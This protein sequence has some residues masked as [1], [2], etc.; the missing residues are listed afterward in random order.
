MSLHNLA[1]M[2]TATTG[3][4]S[5]ITLGSA[6]PGFLTFAQAGVVNGETVPYGII[7]GINSETGTGVYTSAGTTLTRIPTKSTNGDALISLSGNALVSITARAEDIVVVDKA[8]TFSA[9]QTAGSA[10]ITSG[11]APDFSAKQLFT[12]A[13]SGSTF[14]VA[15][16]SADPANNTVILLII[17]FTTANL[18]SFGTEYKVTGYTPSA[19]G[20]DALTF[21]YDS[22]A[23]L[24]YLMGI[25]KGISF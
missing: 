7:D 17:S 4:T 22:A 16:P 21:V 24:Y 25:R 2:T 1:R 9:P 10:A 18:V 19:S 5:P 12:I 11:V 20:K 3:T 13:V 15:N 23:G 6:V 14:T 8:Q